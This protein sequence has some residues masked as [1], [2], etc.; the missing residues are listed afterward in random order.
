[1][2]LRD[3]H[4]ADHVLALPVSRA[5]SV[6]P[7]PS[8]TVGTD[9]AVIDVVDIKSS[10]HALWETALPN[11]AV[12]DVVVEKES[13]LNFENV[14][15]WLAV[16]DEQTRKACGSILATEINQIYETAKGEGYE[17][18]KIAG[19]A[20]AKADIAAQLAILQEL[21]KAAESLYRSEQ[22]QLQDVCSDIVAEAVGKIAGKLLATEEAALGAVREVLSRVKEAREITIRVARDDL[23]RLKTHELDL[24][25]ALSDRKFE[26]VA[27]NRIQLGG[28]IVDSKLGSL[29]GRF[30]VQ[31]RELYET[32]RLAKQSAQEAS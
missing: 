6:Q 22:H 32:L 19:V 24:S 7:V 9:E 13:D 12:P 23:Q 31:L 30:E 25:N 17:A 10:R 11:P 1:M 27:D 8:S 14:V 28:C 2:I 15:A 5:A 18:G 16:Q 29:D 26:I 4:L 20:A 21:S 3:S